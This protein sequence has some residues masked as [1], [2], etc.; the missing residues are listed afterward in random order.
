MFMSMQFTAVGLLSIAISVCIHVCMHKSST[1]PAAHAGLPLP[2]KYPLI[3]ANYVS[4]PGGGG[5]CSICSNEAL[6][7]SS[8][9]I[10]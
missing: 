1:E 7:H 8:V 2:E 5:N 6:R 4:V 9:Y 10:T 3:C